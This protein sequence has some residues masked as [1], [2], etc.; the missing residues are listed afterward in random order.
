MGGGGRRSHGNGWRLLSATSSTSEES[1]KYRHFHTQM[2]IKATEQRV[3][4]RCKA[5]PKI[6]WL[7]E[8]VKGE[9][10][11]GVERGEWGG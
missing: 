4:R 3:N 8:W 10:E 6:L 5:L 7:C 1:P 11:S 2:Y 9:M